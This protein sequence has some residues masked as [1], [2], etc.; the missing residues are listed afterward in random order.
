MLDFKAGPDIIF[1][2]CNN[3]LGLSLRYFV[4]QLKKEGIEVPLSSQS[5]VSLEGLPK[6]VQTRLFF[7]NR[8]TG[9]T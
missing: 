8:A 3:K 1:V 9:G 5:T 6:K 4:K 2:L 7:I